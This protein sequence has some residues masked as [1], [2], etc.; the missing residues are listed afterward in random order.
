MLPAPAQTCNIFVSEKL[1]WL[2]ATCMLRLCTPSQEVKLVQHILTVPAHFTRRTSNL[3]GAE[4]GTGC[5]GG[6]VKGA[7]GDEVS[8]ARQSHRSKGSRVW[9]ES[10]FS[11]GARVGRAQET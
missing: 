3:P 11:V 4:F 9:R 1:S 7:T 10:L 6:G 2:Q 8:G 5:T